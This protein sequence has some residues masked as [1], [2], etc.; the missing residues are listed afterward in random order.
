MTTKIIYITSLSRSGSTILD[1]ILGAHAN[2]VG[3]GEVTRVLG[4]REEQLEKS[5][6]GRVCSCGATARECKVW[7]PYL[8]WLSKNLDQERAEKY[9]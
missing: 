5:L 7:G 1:M 9:R 6:D 2:G 3:L 4:M 8:G